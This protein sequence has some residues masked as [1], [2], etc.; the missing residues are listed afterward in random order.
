ML[1]PKAPPDSATRDEASL[2]S[3]DRRRALLAQTNPA[4]F[5]PL[6]QR[7]VDRVHQYCYRRLGTR[8]AAEDATSLIFEKALQ[9]ISMYRGGSFRAWLFAIAHHVITDHYRAARP[10]I[11]LDD[12]TDLADPALPP[13]TLVLLADEQRLLQTA[14]PLLPIDQ[15]RVMELRL[16]GLPST[17]V[18]VILNR[19]PESVRALQRRAVVK[20]QSLLGVSATSREA[21]YA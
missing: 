14:L 4:E 1:R 18:A 6:Y 13:E 8:E 20:L 15:R 9:G 19:S 5:G 2:Q 11:S 7:Y 10:H 12:T 21:H 3:D 17:E 16:S